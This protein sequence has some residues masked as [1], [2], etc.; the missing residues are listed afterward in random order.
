MIHSPIEDIKSRLDVTELIQ[1]YIKVHKA[2]I[3]YKANCPFHGEKTPSFFISPTRQIWHCFGC[4]RGGDIF[5]FIMEIEGYD[6]PEALKLLAA[7]AGVI[8]KR[9]DPSVR[10]ERNRLYDLAEE[11]AGIFER[12]LSVTPAAKSY[13]RKRGVTDGSIAHFRVGFA[14]QSW[15]FVIRA[16]S[17]KGFKKE[18]MVSA[19]LA[20]H[21]EDRSSWYDRFRGRIMFPIGDT[22]GR[23]IGFGGRIFEEVKD[24]NKDREEAKYINSP[25]TAI[26]DKSHVLFGFDKAKQSIRE[27]N[28][29]V[30]VEGYMDCLMSHQAGVTNSI[31]VSGTALTPQQ[32]KIL[33]RLCDT[34]ISSFDTDAAGQSATKR[35]LGLAAEFEFER[36]IAAIPSGKDPA[37]TVQENAESWVSAVADAKQIVPFYFEQTFKLHN[38]TTA[39]GK[40]AISAVLIPLVAEIAN[41]IEASH[42]VREFA[43]RT[44]APEDA[45]WT[46]IR[47]TRARASSKNQFTPAPVQ[48]QT[49]VLP[50]RR[51]LLEERLLALLAVVPQET[52]KELFKTHAISFINPVNETLFFSLTGLSTTPPSQELEKQLGLIRFKSEVLAQILANPAQELLLCKRELEKEGIKGRLT[53]LGVTIRR[54]ES[55]STRETLEPLLREMTVLT[56]QLK[57]LSQE[58]S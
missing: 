8:L 50:Q 39:D 12:T 2:G 18:E 41:D 13:L 45:I 32:L 37:D 23:I 14:P 27:K 26:Y 10:S 48:V 43:Q 44:N 35:S 42:W 46:E 55:S 15:D 5:K 57:T 19:G 58:T 9:E 47:K 51:E 20:I 11:A 52:S 16:L 3:N 49:P 28:A 38:A 24:S 33:R 7:R 34:V 4:G 22:N 36:K 54:M 25:Q 17:A 56:T 1:S 40:K 29:V 6:F 30:V 21:S 53:E 31:A